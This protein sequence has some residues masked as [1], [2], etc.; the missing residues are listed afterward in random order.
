MR[1]GLNVSNYSGIHGVID[2]PARIVNSPLA[3]DFN[4]SSVG[5]FVDNNFLTIPN[6]S[7]ITIGGK[8]I[9]PIPAGIPRTNL[10]QN[11]YL[12]INDKNFTR[13]GTDITVRGP[14]MMIS[15][16]TKGFGVFTNV[17]SN[18]TIKNIPLDMVNFFFN[19]IDGE[20]LTNLA[21]SGVNINN[22]G[23]NAM[24]WTEVGLSYGKYIVDDRFY[25]VRA[26]G[27][28][29][30]LLGATNYALN[31]N[32]ILAQPDFTKTAI[33]NF[34]SIVMDID[35]RFLN[36]GKVTGGWTNYIAGYGL[37]ID[38]GILIEEYKV[39]KKR[40]GKYMQKYQWQLG[41]SINDIGAIAFG[42]DK[43]ISNTIKGNGLVEILNL[44]TVRN[45]Y[46]QAVADVINNAAT[47]TYSD[48]DDGKGNVVFL[49]ASAT[50]HIDRSI[51]Q[52][53]YIFGKYRMGMPGNHRALRT[54]SNLVIAPRYENKHFDFSIPFTLHDWRHFRYGFNFRASIFTIGSDNLSNIFRETATVTGADI[55][56]GLRFYRN[57]RLLK[58]S[59]FLNRWLAKRKRNSKLKNFRIVSPR[60]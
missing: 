37:G 42:A 43:L 10:N 16:P 45:P 58:K 23:I 36:P 41:I 44:D 49:P 52:N 6:N 51:W 26:G 60:F 53:W 4:L 21:L 11:A 8:N 39:Y 57:R 46:M 17:R 32:Q 9:V 7:L 22:F 15:T 55:Y 38:A 13:I 48:L 34:E 5:V 54:P 25:K 35:Y 2:N 33:E 3:W 30:F 20:N 27:N 18:V 59:N 56:F 47:A 50:V 31:F 12:V 1:T 24:G 19:P 29:K 40:F 14:S 28:L